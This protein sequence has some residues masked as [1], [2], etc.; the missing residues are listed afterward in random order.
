M[1]NR[2]SMPP[3]MVVHR[4]SSEEG[5]VRKTSLKKV[6]KQG[7]EMAGEKWSS[8]MGGAG[9][10]G[11]GREDSKNPGRSTT[12]RLG[13]ASRSS[14]HPSRD[15]RTTPPSSRSIG[16]SSASPSSSR[17]RPSDRTSWFEE[18]ADGE[19]E[20]RV[21]EMAGLGLG[22]A[23]GAGVGRPSSEGTDRHETQT[24]RI[25]SEGVR[26]TLQVQPT[27]EQEGKG[28]T[29][30]RSADTPPIH[31]VPEVREDSDRPSGEAKVDIWDMK[32]LR[33]IAD[34]PENAKCADCG[35]GMRSSRWATISELMFPVFRQSRYGHAVYC[36]SSRRAGI[37]VKLPDATPH[38][39][40]LA[41]STLPSCHPC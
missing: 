11:G 40:V 28:I 23:V 15:G 36:I 16:D 39:G 3:P 19:I 37:R 4:N 13:Q 9:G 21:F 29:R 1:A 8:V 5:R 17:T 38:S 22:L 35:K 33:E 26:G 18:S 14:D 30:A 12:A 41:L 24:R 27:S 31:A 25:Q 10:G 34:R 2:R 20:K 6:W 32:R 7:T